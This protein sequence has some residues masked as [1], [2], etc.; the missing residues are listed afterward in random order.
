[1]IGVQG[2]GSLRK[3]ANDSVTLTALHRCA[4]RSEYLSTYQRDLSR[5]VRHLYVSRQ[6]YSCGR[7]GTTNGPRRQ[8][9]TAGVRAQTPMKTMERC[10]DDG[11]KGQP[12]GEGQMVVGS[13]T[14][15]RRA[16]DGNDGRRVCAKWL[17]GSSDSSQLRRSGVRESNKGLIRLIRFRL[18]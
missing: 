16:D 18:R 15:G 5:A 12:I 14:T 2:L 10:H 11:N 17:R 13:T 6:R 1:M 8:K 4:S 7:H 3:T 9:D